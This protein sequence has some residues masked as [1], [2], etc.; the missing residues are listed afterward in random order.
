MGWGAFVFTVDKAYFSVF[1]ICLLLSMFSVYLF[2]ESLY[3]DMKQ[4][5]EKNET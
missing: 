3:N 5:K 2:L 4:R 1:L